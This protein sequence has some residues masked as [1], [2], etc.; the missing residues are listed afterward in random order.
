MVETDF[1]FKKPKDFDE[2]LNDVTR[3]IEERIAWSKHILRVTTCK[4]DYWNLLWTI[5]YNSINLK[6]SGLRYKQ[7]DKNYI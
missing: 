6:L 2:R 4:W 7:F 5:E 1:T 3:K